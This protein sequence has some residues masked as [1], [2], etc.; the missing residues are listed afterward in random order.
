VDWRFLTV[1][2]DMVALLCGSSEKAR[3]PRR[4]GGQL[5]LVV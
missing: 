2:A 3:E 1:R 4:H 5:D